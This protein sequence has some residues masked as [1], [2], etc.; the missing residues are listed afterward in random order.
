MIVGE[1][2]TKVNLSLFASLPSWEEGARPSRFVRKSRD[3]R[4]SGTSTPRK[5]PREVPGLA[6]DDLSQIGEH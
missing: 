6:V 1:Q 5:V 4:T 3:F 2:K